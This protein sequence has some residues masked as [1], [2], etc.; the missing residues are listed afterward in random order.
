MEIEITRLVPLRNAQKHLKF[1]TQIKFAMFFFY[2]FSY[3]NFSMDLDYHGLRWNL[4]PDLKILRFKV[5]FCFKWKISVIKVTLRGKMSM[6]IE[7]AYLHLWFLNKYN[8]SISCSWETKEQLSESNIFQVRKTTL[9]STFQI[10]FL[11]EPI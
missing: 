4:E 10:K 7:T 6:F 5:F 2:V 8:L 11:R 1:K 9:S 3:S